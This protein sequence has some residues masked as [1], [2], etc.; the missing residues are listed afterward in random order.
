MNALTSPASLPYEW[1]YGVGA[2]LVDRL[3]DSH[4]IA[5]LDA[6][7]AADVQAFGQQQLDLLLVAVA[8]RPWWRH[9]LGGRSKAKLADLPVMQ[10][11]DFQASAAQ[12]LPTL[13]AWHGS[14]VSNSTS[15]SSGIAVKFY[16]TQYASRLSISHF[17]HDHL[18]Q[19]RD[20]SK[21]MVSFTHRGAGNSAGYSDLPGNRFEG[22]FPT[23]LRR[24]PDYSIYEHAHWLSKI[25]AEQAPPYLAIS[26][27]VLA[28][29]FDE[30]EAGT[31][32][33][34]AKGAIEQVLSFGMT[35]DPMLRQR[36]RTLL[37]ASI[38]DRYSC[39]ELGA[40]AFQ[41]PHDDNSFHIARA[42]VILEVVDD[43][44]QPCAP[45]VTGKVLVTG[46]HNHANP[47]LRYD[48]GDEAA[49]APR[50]SCGFSGACLTNLLGKRLGLIRLPDGSRKFFRI[51]AKDFTNIAPITEFRVVQTT[52][53]TVQVQV[54]SATPLTDA[55]LQ[56]IAATL[57]DLISEQLVFEVR[58]VEQIHW[59]AG[60]KR[61]GVTSLLP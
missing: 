18:R 47:V 52:H 23:L 43:T 40:L 2:L 36:C 59:P 19:G 20:F 3:V 16:S 15:G 11:L 7:S 8:Q 5:Q 12:P 22:V 42:N 13:P 28:G 54:V 38:R 21:H 51:A 1:P 27:A 14:P 10:R 4:F 46:L 61:L 48:I 29:I 37:G 25:T 60:A 33:P 6:A 9:W 45:G 34:I 50:C 32:A 56:T 44:G 35:V 49:Y 30:I 55:S 58:Q 17:W 57:S 53:T 31:V 24:V 41:C 26:P 39:E